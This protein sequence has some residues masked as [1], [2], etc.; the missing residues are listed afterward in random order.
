M[1]FF[2]FSFATRFFYI[3]PSFPFPL[4]RVYIFT[5]C[6][7][8]MRSQ[9]EDD[10]FLLPSISSPFHLVFMCTKSGKCLTVPIFFLLF[11]M[12][13]LTEIFFFSEAWN[14]MKGCKDIK[15]AAGEKITS[16]NS[17]DWCKN[18]NSLS[19]VLPFPDMKYIY[20][21]PSIF[22]DS[23]FSERNAFLLLSRLSVFWL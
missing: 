2:L 12:D 9:K 19:V 11:I 18:N 4:L 17:R 6:R 7:E 15:T 20:N 21:K 5:L 16:R 13:F 3:S 10:S 8:W 23:H 14:K 1:I 22:S